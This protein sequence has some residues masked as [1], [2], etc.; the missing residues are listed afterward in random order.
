MTID[1]R[2][3]D[4]LLA[5]AAADAAWPETPDLRTAV[6]ARLAVPVTP[7]LRPGVVARIGHGVRAPRAVP[8]GTPTMGRQRSRLRRS[9]VPLALAAAL[10][11]VVG[12]IAAAL[13]FRLPGA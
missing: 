1:E 12:G 4:A 9:I 7:D 2:R 8:V 11:L 6:V 3:L 13:G 5:Q 10:L